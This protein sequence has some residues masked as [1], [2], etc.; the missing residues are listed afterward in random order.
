MRIK[1]AFIIIF[2]FSVAAVVGFTSVGGS[3][4]QEPSA[5]VQRVK[6]TAGIRDSLKHEDAA[7][8]NASLF[9]DLNWTFGGKQQRG[10]YLY[11]PLI[12]RLLRTEA[13]ANS[14]KFATHLSDW[15]KKRALAPTGVLDEETLMS[16]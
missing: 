14:E 1:I 13:T 3:Q 5:A 8:R 6:P 15:Q 11:I 16:M 12:A 4:S 7:R 9:Y 2:V 10:W